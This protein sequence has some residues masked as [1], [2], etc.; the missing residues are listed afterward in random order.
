M[1]KAGLLIFTLCLAACTSTAD[2]QKQCAAAAASFGQE[3]SCIESLVAQDSYLGGDSFVH[4]Y[5]LEG[6]VLAEK[7]A[8]GEIR[9]SEARLEFSRAYNE[10]ALRQQQY[11][12]YN[13]IQMDQLR[14]RH[15]TCHP[16]G[17]S[18]IC[19]TY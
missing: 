7:L 18:L 5:V 4:Q 14:P 19:D 2:I 17:D 15:T 6:K 3:V 1:R 10:L 13:A 8:A 16:S 9:E 11:Q 12:A